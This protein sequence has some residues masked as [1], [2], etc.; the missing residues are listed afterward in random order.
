MDGQLKKMKFTQ[1]SHDPC[2]YSRFSNGKIFII[3]VYVDDIILA[4][5]SEEDIAHAKES[6]SRR[7]DV[8]DM[9]RIHYFLGVKLKLH[10][11][12]SVKLYC[13]TVETF[14]NG[15]IKSS[16]YTF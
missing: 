14:W 5:D 10:L 1:S 15:R 8:E 13:P 9:G 4:G 16:R 3:A 11:D 2:I 7:F 6:L 12:W